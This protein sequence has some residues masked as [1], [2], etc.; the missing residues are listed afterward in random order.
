MFYI[1]VF[2]STIYTFQYEALV[3]PGNELMVHHILVYRCP[4]AASYDGV[5]GLCYTKDRPLP[6]CSDVILAWAIGGK[7]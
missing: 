6:H 5:Q 1:L 7:V 2:S 3:T 4:I